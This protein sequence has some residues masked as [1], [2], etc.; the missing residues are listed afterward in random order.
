MLVSTSVKLLTA[1]YS[2]TLESVA[3]CLV[4]VTSAFKCLP[5]GTGHLRQSDESAELYYYNN[6]N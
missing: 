2:Y 4:S 6:E 1:S 5:P 3:V